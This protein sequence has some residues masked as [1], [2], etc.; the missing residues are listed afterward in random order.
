[1]RGG[2]IAKVKRRV[3]PH[4]H[5]IDI[6]AKVDLHGFAKAEMRPL[7]RFDRDRESA[8]R[9]AAVPIVEVRRKIME[10]LMPPLLRCEHQ[11]ESRIPGNFDCMHRVHLNS[12][13]QGNLRSFIN[14]AFVYPPCQTRSEEHTSELQSLI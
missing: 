5:H 4:E 8:G 9:Q 7:D 1:M 10:Q 12:D 3:L 2:D 6:T 11:I 13:F 14:D